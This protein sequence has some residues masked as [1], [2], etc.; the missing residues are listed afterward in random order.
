MQ[1]VH[2]Y[3]TGFLARCGVLLRRLMRARR[4]ETEEYALTLSLLESAFQQNSVV[5]IVTKKY[6][7]IGCSLQQKHIKHNHVDRPLCDD[8]LHLEQVAITNNGSVV[9]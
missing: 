7:S 8:F 2:Q 1:S 4:R 3:Q 9:R 6:G 5:A